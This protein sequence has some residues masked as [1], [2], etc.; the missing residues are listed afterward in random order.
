MTFSTCCIESCMETSICPCVKLCHW[1]PVIGRNSYWL[2][3]LIK[4]IKS[5]DLSEC[6]NVAFFWGFSDHSQNS[7]C[8]DNRELSSSDGHCSFHQQWLD[9][10]N[11]KDAWRVRY[12]ASVIANT[13]RFILTWVISCFQSSLLP[14][15]ASIWLAESWA[16]S[17]G[18]LYML[19]GTPEASDYCI[20]GKHLNSFTWFCKIEI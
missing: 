3:C 12:D 20:Q 15:Q 5:F 17:V 14:Q 13:A 11:V 2:I 6:P 4:G 10:V 9:K 19:F 8:L 1:R 18:T 16:S 7:V